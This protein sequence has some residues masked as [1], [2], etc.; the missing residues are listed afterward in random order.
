MRV[1]TVTDKHRTILICLAL[2]AATCAV[3]AQVRS[4][5]FVNFDDQEYVTRNHHVNTG[6]SR[7]NVIWALTESHSCNWHP[8]TWISHMLDCEIADLH[9]A[10]HHMVNVLFH[11][12]NTLLLFLLVRQI[13]GAVWRSAFVAAAFAL[14][15]VHVE[16]V[17]WI[18]ERKDV[19]STFFWLLTMIAYARYAQKPSI[20]RYVLTMLFLAL[21]LMSKPM[22]VTLPVILLLMDYWPLG[23]LNLSSRAQHNDEGYQQNC[24]FPSP[25]AAIR[26]CLEKVPFLALCVISSGVTLLVQSQT[27]APFDGLP[28][29]IRLANASLSYVRYLV[30]MTWPTRLSAFYPHPNRDIRLWLAALVALALIAVSLLVIRLS[31]RHKYLAFGWFWYL[32]TLLPV[33][34]VVQVG[35]QAMADRYTYVPS[36]G[37]F[38]IAAWAIPDLL[39]NKPAFARLVPPIGLA[40]VLTWSVMTYIQTGYWRNTITLFHHACDVTDNNTF[41]HQ[42]LAG[43]YAQR[44][45][46]DL[47]VDNFE[48][49]LRIKPDDRRT[50]NGMAWL[51]ATCPDSEFRNPRR[52][53]GYAWRASQQS[54]FKDPAHL[55]TLAAAYAADG[56][57]ADAAKT[58]DKALALTPERFRDDYEKRLE[59][60]EAGK[61]FI[62]H[63]P[64]S[65]EN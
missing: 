25:R 4:F 22:L 17:A 12:L 35:A 32:I 46:F 11:A 15:P 55:D 31:K 23:R 7:S 54:D 47:A 53:F 44:G 64:D 60:Y 41:M 65:R 58:Q 5:D 59:L 40:V 9:A 16:S 29:H 52:A 49:A 27:R 10:W 63:I 39:R 43:E 6:L 42:S 24:T 13:T 8:L 36:I 38:I 19:L 33:I 50:L 62:D 45:D 3:Y 14:H 48:Q 26:L 57:F 18:S 28:I 51:L 21:G 20:G 1:V 61:P 56:N 2:A 30:K 37:I 34:G